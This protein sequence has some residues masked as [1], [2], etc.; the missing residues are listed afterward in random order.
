[1]TLAYAPL[2][3]VI[4]DARYDLSADCLHAH[5]LPMHFQTTEFDR[6]FAGLGDC[7]QLTPGV[8]EAKGR[9]VNAPSARIADLELNCGVQIHGDVDR[10]RLHLILVRPAAGSRVLAN[11]VDCTS[12]H[13][14]V[15]SG[16]DLSVN[17]LGAAALLWFDI[18]R[19]A[20]GETAMAIMRGT[21]KAVLELSASEAALLQNYATR[22]FEE[23][24]EAEEPDATIDPVLKEL[25]L[26]LLARARATVASRADISREKLIRR[27]Q[28][29]MWASI[30]E[31]PTLRDLCVAA[32]CS[33]RTLIYAF[34]ATFGMS[35]MKYFKI[36]RL[37]VAHRK[38]Q[39]AQPGTHIFDVA[40]DCGFWHL[41]HFGVDYKTLFG[42]TPKMTSGHQAPNVAYQAC[43]RRDE[44]PC[45]GLWCV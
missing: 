13:C 44:R 43:E 32:K 12:K 15:V 18:D 2:D 35:P 26:S 3:F 36:Q 30:E 10:G 27:V 4:P 16:G 34:N 37:N 31:P 24:S 45:A 28:A 21:A 42:A 5:R 19:R 33:V 40:A 38:F 8:F 29:L 39:N 20:L 25:A 7:M 11:A 41:G 9:R 17:V 1:L 6:L 22:R 14:L 23:P